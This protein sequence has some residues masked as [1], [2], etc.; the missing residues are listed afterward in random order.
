MLRNQPEHP[1]PSQIDNNSYWSF[2]KESPGVWAPR[3]LTTE[4]CESPG[5]WGSMVVS[6]QG[7]ESFLRA[8]VSIPGVILHGCES[9]GV[10]SYQTCESLGECPT[11]G[12]IL[13][14]C[15]S[16]IGRWIPTHVGLKILQVGHQRC[17]LLAAGMQ[18]SRDVN[19]QGL[20]NHQGCKLLGNLVISTKLKM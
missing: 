9:L 12:C 3:D 14:G 15:E 18:V 8:W 10:R 7:C 16:P 4:R 11:K 20:V 13:Q 2:F 19:A 1:I 17:Y 5:V 6:L